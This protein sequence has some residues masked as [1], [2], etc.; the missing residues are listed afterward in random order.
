MGAGDREFKSLYPDTFTSDEEPL[1]NDWGSVIF[2]CTSYIHPF[3]NF[4]IYNHIRD[5]LKFEINVI[6][7]PPPKTNGDRVRMSEVHTL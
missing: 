3:S 4:I 7:N 6:F 2:R 1:F 5:T